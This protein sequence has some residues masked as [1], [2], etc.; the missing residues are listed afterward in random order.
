MSRC[1]RWV[2]SHR[3]F[4]QE[5]ILEAE[6]IAQGWIDLHTSKLSKRERAL[7]EWANEALSEAI[8]HDTDYAFDIIEAI[9]EL[10]PDQQAVE[11]FA[12]G[13]IEDILSY[14]GAMVIDRIEQKALRDPSFA[15]ALGGVWQRAMPESIWERVV[16]CRECNGWSGVMQ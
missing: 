11:R 1:P 13:P 5:M 6:L 7:G 9:H 2:A 4:A 14:Q 10:D 3:T 8:C 16:A 12:S 15:F